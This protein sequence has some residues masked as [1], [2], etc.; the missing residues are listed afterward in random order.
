MSPAYG[1]WSPYERS[2]DRIGLIDCMDNKSLLKTLI[3]SAYMQKIRP[4]EIGDTVNV[5]KGSYRLARL[6]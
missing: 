5:S 4:F 3:S 1:D 2:R 6:L